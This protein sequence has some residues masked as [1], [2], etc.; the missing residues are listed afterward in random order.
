MIKAKAVF[1]PQMFWKQVQAELVKARG[2]KVEFPHY[3]VN[4]WM[5][6]K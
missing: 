5:V 1:L 6:R 2:L 3:M 4:A